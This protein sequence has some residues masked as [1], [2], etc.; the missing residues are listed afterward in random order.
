[1]GTA[2]GAEVASPSV[3][4]AAPVEPHR[5]EASPQALELRE[6]RIEQGVATLLEVAVGLVV[7]PSEEALPP[8]GPLRVVDPEQPGRPLFVDASAPR[9]RRRYA[10]AA[11]ARRRALERRL[12]GRGVDSVWLSTAF[13]PAG[14]LARFFRE[15]TARVRWAS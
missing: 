5:V 12:R 1:V 3:G 15:R 11:A 7:D 14:A 10:A 8:I 6:D 4:P 13:P 9:V 2:S